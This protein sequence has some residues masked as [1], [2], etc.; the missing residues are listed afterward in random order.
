LEQKI[1]KRDPDLQFVKQ[2]NS[3]RVLKGNLDDNDQDGTFL[4]P[5]DLLER[6]Q[7]TFF[8]LFFKISFLVY[9]SN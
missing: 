3:Y 9:L 2:K 7:V 8:V 6:N 5:E 1:L 4:S